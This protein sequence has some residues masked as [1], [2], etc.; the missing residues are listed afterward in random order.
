MSLFDI[1]SKEDK[2]KEL[3]KQTNDANFWNDTENS[4]K[5]LQEIKFLKD[6]VTNYNSLEVQAQDLKDMIEISIEE[7]FDGSMQDIFSEF[8]QLSKGVDKLETENLLSGPHDK[9]N[10][11][12]TIHPGAG[13]TESQDWAQMLYRMYNMWSEKNGFKLL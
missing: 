10:A 3:E 7:N 9:N 13:G 4:S 6:K 12:V 11:I 2:L 8:K 5:V 1:S